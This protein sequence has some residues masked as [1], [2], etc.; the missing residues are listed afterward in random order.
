MSEQRRD[1]GHDVGR[2]PRLRKAG[3]YPTMTFRRTLCPHCRTKLDPGQRIH[4]HC[5]AGYAEAEGAKAER[6]RQKQARAAARVEKAETRRRKEAI[7]TI[8]DLI[9]EAQ[10]AFNAFIRERDRAKPCICCGLPL[11]AGEVGGAFD[12]GHYRSTGSASHLRFDERNAHA[13]RKVCTAG[14][15]AVL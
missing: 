8:P 15:L 14:V 2:K 10:V 11:G 7:K 3:V 9:K 12:C 6:K 4:S 5:I 13:Q 1:L